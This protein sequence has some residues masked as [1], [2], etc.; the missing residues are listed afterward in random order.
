MARRGSVC[1]FI[2]CTGIYCRVLQI[3]AADD[4]SGKC[5]GVGVGGSVGVEEEGKKG[6]V[7][8]L[9]TSALQTLTSNGLLPYSNTN[10]DVHI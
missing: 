10:S 5:V 8:C 3:M 6:R 9:L 1:F 7:Q 2:S 4:N